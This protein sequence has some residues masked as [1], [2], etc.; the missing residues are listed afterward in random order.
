MRAVFSI[1][2]QLRESVGC[3]GVVVDAKAGA[4]KYY[5]SYGFVEIEVVEGQLE[6]RPAP[7]PIFLPL[8]AVD[9]AM[10]ATKSREK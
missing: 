7:K 4:E 3:I 6:E 10:R 1:A 9:A 2:L 8:A 5:E